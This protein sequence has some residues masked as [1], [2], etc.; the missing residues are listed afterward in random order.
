LAGTG[1]AG[2]QDGLAASS[3]FTFPTGICFQLDG[4]IL[5]ADFANNRLRKIFNGN[6][7]T[8][9]GNGTAGFNSDFILATSALLNIPTDCTVD[10]MGNIYIADNQNFRLRKILVLNIALTAL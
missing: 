4:G 1:T 3:N 8:V 5:V 10:S 6:V 9:A 2:F 7:T